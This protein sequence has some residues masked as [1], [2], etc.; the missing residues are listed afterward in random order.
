[1][2]I[3]NDNDEVTISTED[4]ELLSSPTIITTYANY[5]TYELYRISSVNHDLINFTSIINAY[6]IDTSSVNIKVTGGAIQDS[7]EH[8]G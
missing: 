5:D 8:G 1:M 6:T 4:G 3:G 7:L 2:K